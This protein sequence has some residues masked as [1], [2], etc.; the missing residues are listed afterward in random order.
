MTPN[1]YLSILFFSLMILVLSNS[2]LGLT[3]ISQSNRVYVLIT[4]TDNTPLPN[5]TVRVCIGLSTICE[6]NRTDSN[7]LT[8]VDLKQTSDSLRIYI[9]YGMY[10][11]IYYRR[12]SYSGGNSVYLTIPFKKLTINCSVVDEYLKPV[13]GSFSLFYRNMLV[14]TDRFYERILINETSLTSDLLLINTR[15]PYEDVNERIIGLE[16]NLVVSVDHEQETYRVS[17]DNIPM[18]RVIIDL[19]KPAINLLN[20]TIQY[21]PSKQTPLFA[22]VILYFSIADGVNTNLLKIEVAYQWESSIESVVRP[23]PVEKN[24]F[25]TIYRLE[26]DTYLYKEYINKLLIIKIRAVDPHTRS[27][28]VTE[29]LNVWSSITSSGGDS[30]INTSVSITVNE[31]TQRIGTGGEHFNTSTRVSSDDYSGFEITTDSSRVFLDYIYLIGLIL[32]VLVLF[33]EIKR[34]RKERSSSH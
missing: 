24:E 6:T 5:A 10:G 21:L 23:E 20:S 14:S 22:K 26:F 34:Y 31:Q 18:D 28:E 4:L 29:Y 17:Y 11:E 3:C 15:K 7:G 19:H 32:S 9:E 25:V 8:I 13:N 27:S 2:T 33:I 12:I 30:S 1:R 16:Y